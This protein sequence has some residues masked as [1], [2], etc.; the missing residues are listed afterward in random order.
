MKRRRETQYGG[1]ASKKRVTY[2]M[3]KKW[4]VDFDRDS[5]TMIWLEC[6]TATE[7]GKRVVEK[8]KCKVCT[9]FADRIRGRKNF[10]E[11]WIVGADSV[12]TS[13]VCDHAHNDQHKH[14]M[15]LLTKK[16][17]KSSGLTAVS[18]APIAKAFNKLPEDERER[19]TVKFDIAY[20]MS[21]EKL[22]YTH[23]PKICEF[24]S[25]HGVQVGTS[26]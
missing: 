18:Y 7:G 24:E 19:L 16:R 11:K 23:Y 4:L 15:S 25:R 5:N 10:S 26:Y 3:F 1:G 12:R 9:R 6:K 14:A 20:F 13:N 22:P 17:A 2:E 8:L 21:T